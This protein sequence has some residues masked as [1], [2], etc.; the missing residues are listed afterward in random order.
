MNSK[1]LLQEA[2][3]LITDPSRWTTHW[4]ARDDAGV[5]CDPVGEEATCFCAI[6][7][8]LHVT[9][10][11]HLDLL[12]DFQDLDIIN[13]GPDGHARVLAV[14]DKAIKETP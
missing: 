2:R 13:D 14:L 8:L 9:K 1:K 5:P 7:A 12:I 6:G 3:D 10:G 11:D 4:L